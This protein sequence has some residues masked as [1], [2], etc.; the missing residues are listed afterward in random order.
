M[1]NCTLGNSQKKAKKQGDE[2]PPDDIGDSNTEK[3]EIS[4]K[5]DVTYTTVKHCAVRTPARRTKD[6]SE[7]HCF[8]S[9]VNLP[10]RLK[11]S[12]E[13]SLTEECSDDYVLMG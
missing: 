13:P 2:E 10:S 8:Y 7:D 5:E 6:S 3:E 1:G 9:T 4:P 11:S 12:H